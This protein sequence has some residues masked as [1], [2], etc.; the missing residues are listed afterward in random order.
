MCFDFF[1]TEKVDTTKKFFTAVSV[2]TSWNSE[3]KRIYSAQV[4]L[5]FALHLFYI[6]NQ[7]FKQSPRKSLI[8]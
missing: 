4:T 3:N 2:F 1:Y 5:Y 6:S 8:Y 7:I